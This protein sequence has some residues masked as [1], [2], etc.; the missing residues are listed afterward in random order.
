MACIIQRV[1]KA[2]PTC[3]FPHHIRV[4]GHHHPVR[5]AAWVPTTPQTQPRHVLITAFSNATH[6]ITNRQLT[7]FTEA[8]RGLVGR[9]LAWTEVLTR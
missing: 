2:L 6:Q 4:R 1:A 9:T 8:T 3:V 5:A 7:L